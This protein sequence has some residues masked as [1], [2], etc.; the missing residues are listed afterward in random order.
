[1][2]EIKINVK[3]EEKSKRIVDIEVPVDEINKEIENT[4]NEVQKI[5]SMPG[6]RQG[7]VPRNL[8][9]QYYQERIQSETLDKLIQDAYKI[10]CDK[11][12]I[13]PIGQAQVKDVKFEKDKPLSF[14]AEVEVVPEV[15]LRYYKNIDVDAERVRIDNKDVDD[16]LKQIQER[17][18]EYTTLEGRSAEKGDVVTIDFTGFK[19][20]KPI[21]KFKAQDLRVEIGSNGLMPEIEQGI[22]GMNAEGIEKEILIKLPKDY[23]DPEL[24]EKEITIKV[25][26]KLIQEKKLPILDDEFAKDIG[27]CQSLD[28]LKN[29]IENDL[30]KTREEEKKT[31]IEQKILKEIVSITPVDLPDSLVERE[32]DNIMNEIKDRMKI[33]NVKDFESLKTNENEVKEKYRNVAVEKVKAH[34]IIEEIA[35]LEKIETAEEEVLQE[36]VEIKSR[37]RRKDPK[38]L[39]YLSSDSIKERVKY[40]IRIRK[41]IDFLYNNAKINWRASGATNK[42]H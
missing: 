30:R 15:K 41:T 16:V 4:I 6:F 34:L 23:P 25:R 21:E 32:L 36:I 40:D 14:R 35:K 24:Q 5:A 38:M 13:I 20:G 22:I 3:K 8:V 2:E 1:M 28:E 37:I 26:L 10:A 9:I 33:E 17:M 7:K 11:E 18:A 29:K 31:Q 27:E 39:E 12:N 42:E 19:D